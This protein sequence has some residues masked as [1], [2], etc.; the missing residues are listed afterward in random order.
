ME[1]NKSSIY[2][3]APVL[4]DSVAAVHRGRDENWSIKEIHGS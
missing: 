4:T 2:S 3:R 1:F